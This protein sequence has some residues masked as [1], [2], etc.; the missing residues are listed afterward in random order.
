MIFYFKKKE[1][2]LFSFD[3]LGLSCWTFSS[4]SEQ[5][6]LSSCCAGASHCVTSLVAERG[7]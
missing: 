7:L 2:F 5:R 1:I 6:L 3:C 4:C